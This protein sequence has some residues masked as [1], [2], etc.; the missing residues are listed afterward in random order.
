[1][2]KILC[3]CMCLV[4]V[5]L[6]ASAALA[7]DKL[8][9]INSVLKKGTKKRVEVKD[10]LS[11]YSTSNG[12][13]SS[14]GKKIKLLILERRSPEKEFT[15]LKKDAPI[16]ED[17]GFPDDFTGKDTGKARIW[18][19]GDLM[20]KLPSANRAKSLKDATY[21]LM[22]E[23]VYLHSS[24][25]MN[26][27]YEKNYYSEP[28]EFETTEEMIEYFAAHQPVLASVTYYPVF[29]AYSLVTLYE[30]KTKKFA[31]VESK[32][33][34]GK[35]FA[36]N[37]DAALQWNNMG[38]VF[39]LILA[40][41]SDE[42]VNAATVKKMIGNMSFVPEKQK[43]VWTACIDGEEYDTALSSVFGYYWSMAETLKSLD[44]DM[45]HRENYD[46]IIAS[47]DAIALSYY[48]K[49]CNYSGFEKT[50]DSIR[51]SKEYLA[52]PDWD[53]LE[54]ALKSTLNTMLGK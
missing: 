43:S 54:K 25:L 10:N 15:E 24:T 11:A 47:R 36:R 44:T 22:A 51:E 52:A 45:K 50:I 46:L 5:L 26:Y 27:I 33:T 17:E 8:P 6:T 12:N 34:E 38:Q 48:V 53:W 9:T 7:A 42:G 23:D 16:T 49:Y 4:M 14:L 3:I 41:Q 32:L 13:F 35:L 2:K 37:P 31:V 21:I 40:L 1:M 29:A 28:P 19:R 39:D 20:A 18:V 30:V